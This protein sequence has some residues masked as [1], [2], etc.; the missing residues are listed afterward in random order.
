M[1]DFIAGQ[2]A[3]VSVVA[4]LALLKGTGSCACRVGR[5][6]PRANEMF[7]EQGDDAAVPR[8]VKTSSCEQCASR[9]EGRVVNAVQRT[10]E[11]LLLDEEIGFVEC[12][13]RTCYPV[14][15]QRVGRVHNGTLSPATF[16][17]N[18]ASRHTGSFS[19]P[20]VTTRGEM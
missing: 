6:E 4:R 12:H 13:V 19:I 15:S 16:L 3:E 8:R 14:S 9:V 20:G 18:G 5:H 2:F 1:V 7:L 17:M 11:V 10:T